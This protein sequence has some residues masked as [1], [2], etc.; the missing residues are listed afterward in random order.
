M[1]ATGLMDA[2]E[3]QWPPKDYEV[4]VA[5]MSPPEDISVHLLVALCIFAYII[6]GATGALGALTLTGVLH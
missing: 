2:P 6:G 4:E 1:N 5:P 3:P